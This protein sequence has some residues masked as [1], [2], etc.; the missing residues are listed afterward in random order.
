LK[1]G[2]GEY[3]CEDEARPDDDCGA[4]GGARRGGSRARR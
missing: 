1:G 3:A 2:W 4:R